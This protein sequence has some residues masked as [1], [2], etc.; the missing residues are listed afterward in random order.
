M[1]PLSYNLLPAL[2]HALLRVLSDGETHRVRVAGLGSKLKGVWRAAAFTFISR[3]GM[4][5]VP[6]VRSLLRAV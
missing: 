4:S 1:V 3:V 2:P 6:A 5:Q